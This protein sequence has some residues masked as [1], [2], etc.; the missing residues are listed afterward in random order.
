MSHQ[1]LSKS[2]A[3]DAKK[4]KSE[5]APQVRT[6]RKLYLEQGVR[7]KGAKCQGMEAR[8][9]TAAALEELVKLEHQAYLRSKTTS[10]ERSKWKVMV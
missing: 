9:M 7:S 3:R 1:I 10:N 5:F 2:L 6:A 4:L 8:E